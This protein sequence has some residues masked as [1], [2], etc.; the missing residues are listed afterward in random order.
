[1]NRK[2]TFL[3]EQRWHWLTCHGDLGDQ[4]KTADAK[5]GMND[6]REKSEADHLWKCAEV[7]IKTKNPSGKTKP[8]RER[9]QER[10]NRNSCQELGVEAKTRHPSA[11]NKYLENAAVENEPI[12]SQLGRNKQMSLP[13]LVNVLTA[14]VQRLSRG[15]S[16]SAPTLRFFLL[17]FPSPFFFKSRIT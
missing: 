2:N 15:N 10:R 1:M 8:T 13:P 14:Q 4:G 6:K 11:I 7:K 12:S 9:E 5:L 3:F 16:S 17:V